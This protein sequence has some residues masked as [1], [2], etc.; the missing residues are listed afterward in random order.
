MSEVKRLSPNFA[1][2]STPWAH[3]MDQSRS[4]WI[5][6]SATMSWA[7][8]AAFLQHFWGCLWKPGLSDPINHLGPCSC[9][10]VCVRVRVCDRHTDRERGWRRHNDSKMKIINWKNYIILI[11]FTCM[12]I[13]SQVLNNTRSLTEQMSNLQRGLFRCS[14]DFACHS[15]QTFGEKI[16]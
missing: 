5:S 15:L 2:P 7:G 11:T 1:L 9:V 13:F 10:C 4:S 8:L 14:M 12:Y 3:G 6:W 16:F